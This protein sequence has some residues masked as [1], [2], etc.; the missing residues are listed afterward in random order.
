MDSTVKAVSIPTAKDKVDN[1]FLSLIV[2]ATEV[3]P[4]I[5]QLS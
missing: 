5:T 2:I 1:Y 4:V 3:H